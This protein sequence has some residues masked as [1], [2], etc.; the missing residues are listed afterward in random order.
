MISYASWKG[1]ITARRA[2]DA[3][4]DGRPDWCDVTMRTQSRAAD[5]SHDERLAALEQE[6]ARLRAL[7][8]FSQEAS[9]LL[10]PLRSASGEIIDFE[11][12][13]I[14]TAGC[15]AVRIA[16][17][18]AIGGRLLDL[19]P[20]HGSTAGL[21]EKYR[22]VVETGDPHD[23][24]YFYSGDNVDGWWRN[25]AMPYGDSVLV[26]FSNVTERR[27]E[28]LH[29]RRLATI[30]EQS[31]DFIGIALPSGQVE[32]VNDAGK[33]M[34]G[35]ADADAARGKNMM[36]YF[37]PASRDIV[38]KVAI[39]TMEAQGY[40]EGELA[41]RNFETGDDVP[42]LYTLFPVLDAA[43]QTLAFATVTRDISEM[44]AI[45]DALLASEAKFRAIADTLP[46]MIWSTTPD[47]LH[48]YYNARWYE[49]T[50]VPEGSTDG[51]GWNGMFHPEDQPRAWARWKH[52]LET[53]EP[54]DIE[55]RLRHHT[56]AYRWTLG[57]ALPIRDEKGNILRWFGS[58]TDIHDS[59]LDS[60]RLR[61]ARLRLQLALSAAEIGVWDFDPL[62]D[63]VNWDERIIAAAGRTGDS[64]PFSYSRD[65]L[66]IVHPD[67]RDRVDAA[68]RATVES[69]TDLA[70][71]YRLRHDGLPTDL[72]VASAGKRFVGTDGTARVIGTA[73]DITEDVRALEQREVIAQELS[74]RIKNIFSVISGMI[75]LS[76]RTYPESRVVADQ[77]RARIAALGRAHDFV[78]P[79]NPADPT[80]RAPARLHG[81]VREIFRPYDEDGEPP[82]RIEG[83]DVAIDD[84]AATPLALLFHELATNAAK[85]GALS[86][87]GH[88]ELSV[89]HDG[90]DIVID[91]KER[92]GP[93]VEKEPE[94]QGFG[95]RLTNL[96]VE[97]QLGGTLEQHWEHDGLRCRLRV[98]VKAFARQH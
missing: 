46:Q 49:F 52:S 14:N 2:G 31:N 36:D 60:E 65:F 22:Q 47:G 13:E 9:A 57:R 83:D 16:R 58:C 97:A 20:A 23:I 88:V 72:W 42:I 25:V 61:D 59:K 68:I 29:S 82:I 76:A 18:K 93:P 96:S 21:F 73:M 91:W 78:R 30:V 85:Y 84:R 74:H 37:T 17:E 1:T 86:N 7:C 81:L 40:W 5:F 80:G 26:R 11:C 10:S 63:T 53:G 67:D 51:K 69:G 66:P 48:D 19:L 44:R 54:Y 56:G 70:V 3:T 94:H 38:E 24:E 32:F 87:N 43:R 71:E 6:N 27:R 50:G 12:V 4:R 34:V 33:R 8:D 77:L 92:G 62:R 98:P 39:P 41:F 45:T 95:T 15:E 79:R 55:Y 35:L 28:E 90:D 75:G 64:N 89:R